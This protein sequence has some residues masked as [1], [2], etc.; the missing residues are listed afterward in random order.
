[1]VG[2]LGESR[3]QLGH[4]LE[5]K[6][7]D[8]VIIGNAGAVELDLLAGGIDAQNLAMNHV[9]IPALEPVELARDVF[10]SPLTDHE[11]EERGHE[12]VVRAPIDQR[13]IVVGA[14]GTAEP[15]RGDNAAASAAEDHDS[16][17]PVQHVK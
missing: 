10:D 16:F 13:D 4:R 12:D 3:N 1:M 15:R 8:Q 5:P 17:A 2:R 7:N 11:E 6:R 9:D 14:E